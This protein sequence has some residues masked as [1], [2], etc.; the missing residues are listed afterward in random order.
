MLSANKTNAEP[1]SLTDVRTSILS[2]LQ[3]ATAGTPEYTKLLA[4]LKTVE[5]LAPTQ[6]KWVFKPSADVLVNGLF[7]LLS[8]AAI[9]NHEQLAVITSKATSLLPKLIR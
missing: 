6:P 7:T 8:I 5:E 1:W 3:N 4:D 2:A 9:T